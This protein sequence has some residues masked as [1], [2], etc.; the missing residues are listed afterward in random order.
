MNIT[1]FCIDIWH[2]LVKS[3]NDRMRQ[4]QLAIITINVQITRLGII[5]LQFFNN[6]Y[7]QR[8][9]ENLDEIIQR[10]EAPYV[11]VNNR[12]IFLQ[13]DK[14]FSTSITH[15]SYFNFTHLRPYIS[16]RG[17]VKVPNIALDAKLV[18]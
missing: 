14:L 18:T 15:V 16:V 10:A 9:V 3:F 6:E 5:S 11:R 4:K 2:K 17:P 12:D 1:L 8:M 13:S 7:V